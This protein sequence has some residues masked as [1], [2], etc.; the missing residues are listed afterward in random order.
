[1]PQYPLMDPTIKHGLDQFVETVTGTFGD[2]LIAVVL[3]GSG[4]EDR[5]RPVS[6]LNLI[7]VLS[8]Y[9]LERAAAFR[10]RSAALRA[11][12][13]IRT[14]FILDHEVARAA[15]TF[16]VKFSDIGRRH[17]LL[18][19]AS[20]PFAGLQVD[21]AAAI[22]DLREALFD[23]ALRLRAQWVVRGG[24]ADQLRLAAAE[25]AGGMRACAGE[26]LTLEGSPAPSPRE[27]LDTIAGAPLAALTAA[28][29]TADVDAA[30]AEKLF[31]HLITLVGTMRD[32]A[33][34]LV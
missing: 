4:A 30:T 6:D 9:S 27:A 28:R 33:E 2:Q 19:G 20:D 18:W 22:T 23:L 24:S 14:M 25:A 31:I 15:Q 21:R 5:L 17:R 26:L 11:A 13:Q 34:R 12:L 3:F 10:E 7:I 32:R 29:T 1:M 8:T 16:A